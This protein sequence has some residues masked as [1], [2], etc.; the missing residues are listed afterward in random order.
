MTRRRALLSGRIAEYLAI[1]LLSAKGYRYLASN[2]RTRRGEVDLI[3]R[4]ANCLIFVEVKY[5]RRR[6]ELDYAI[7]P[8][9]WRRIAQAGEDY[10]ARHQNLAHL[11]RRFDCVLFGP[12]PRHQIDVWRS[13][14]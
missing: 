4:K 12:W 10:V 6:S 8:Q 5:R 7:L 14:D 3:M 13:F 2:F 9:Q 11:N 1:I